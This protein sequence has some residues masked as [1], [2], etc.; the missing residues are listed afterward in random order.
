ML[1]GYNERQLVVIELDH[2]QDKED[3]LFSIRAELHDDQKLKAMKA[4]IK[5]PKKTMFNRV[6]TIKESIQ[7]YEQE[8]K[9]KGIKSTRFAEYQSHKSKLSS[10]PFS[11]NP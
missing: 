2:D 10:N 3:S 8:Y 4:D 9:D 11:Q 7:K 6:H 1:I 5:Y